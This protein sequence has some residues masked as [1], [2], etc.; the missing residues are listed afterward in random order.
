LRSHDPVSI[1]D[2]AAKAGLAF[3]SSSADT[4]IK[5]ACAQSCTQ[6]LRDLKQLWTP[7]LGG[8]ES[9]G[10]IWHTSSDNDQMHLVHD[11]A[12]FCSETPGSVLTELEMTVPGVCEC[13]SLGAPN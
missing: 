6:E 12:E 8:Q 5:S 11:F 1:P 4:W 13:S 7:R 2:L 9:P 3:A 10:P